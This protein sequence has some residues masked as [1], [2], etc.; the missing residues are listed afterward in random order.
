MIK[1]KKYW[2][3]LLLLCGLLLTVTACRQKA[4]QPVL[5]KADAST[6]LV[7]VKI[8][9]NDLYRPQAKRLATFLKREMVQ[10]EG[11]Y[12]NIQNTSTR[13]DVATG[14]EMLSESS[15][16]W[17]EYLAQT[18]SKK[19][20]ADFYQQTKDTFDQKG[21]QFSYR[22]DPES[23]KQYHVNATLDDLR[24]LRALVMY[25]ARHQTDKYR[26]EASQRF[27]N[28]KQN[29]LD[30]GQ[31][32][33]YYDIK[34]KKGNTSGSLAYFDLK[35]LRYF[36]DKK[37]YQK[38]LK[39]LKGGYLG[40]VFPLYASSFDWQTNQYANTDLN[41]SEALETLLHLSEIG[42]LKKTSRQWLAQ[43]VKH[44]NLTNSYTTNGVSVNTNQSAANYALAAAIFANVGDQT[45]YEQAMAL[46]WENQATEKQG[47]L[48]GGLFQ[49]GSKKSYS[50]NNL[51]A[52]LAA[53]LASKN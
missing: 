12:T 26:K 31:L 18:G 3:L 36:E 49:D 28:L 2:G 30:D 25:D 40:D 42:A 24:I 39:V 20:F 38:Q 15:G 8:Q 10:K 51:T 33:D 41:T 1:N 9:Q 17:L 4:A 44:K 14:H 11:I 34:Q 27:A 37:T 21:L 22:Y 7:P 35:T 16:L 50:F 6:I 53:Q 52:L 5:P 23:D 45:H 32:I 48:A 47:K 43:Q 29:C 13:K 19:A 46:V